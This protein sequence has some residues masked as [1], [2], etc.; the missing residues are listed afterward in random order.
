MLKTK[1]SLISF[2]EKKTKREWSSAV[3]FP[4]KADQ[5]GC[6]KKNF[7]EGFQHVKER[8][9]HPKPKETRKFFVRYQ[10]SSYTGGNTSW[11]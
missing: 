5:S 7:P 4:R 10:R 3:V 9:L 11:G 6:Q 8:A 2:H 1:L